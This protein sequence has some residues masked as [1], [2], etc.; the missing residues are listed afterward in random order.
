M[1]EHQV[2]SKTLWQATAAALLVGLVVLVTLVWPAEYG[3]D[4]TGA[5]KALGLTALAPASSTA[6]AQPDDNAANAEAAL[7]GQPK[8]VQLVV[9]ANSGLEYKMSM[10]AGAQVDYQ[11]DAG[12][13]VY[14]DMHGEPKGDSTG[15]FKSYTVAKADSMKGSFIAPFAGSH[16][17]YFEN[18]SWEPVEITLQFSGEYSHPRML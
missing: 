3:L 16:G 9:P 6:N 18:D 7:A 15:Y 5:G 17:W 13:R 12:S 1:A 8:T 4:P 10:V 14:V 11:W 2:P